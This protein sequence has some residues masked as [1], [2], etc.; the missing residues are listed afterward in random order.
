L[1]GLSETNAFGFRQVLEQEAVG[2]IT[3][4]V[5]CESVIDFFGV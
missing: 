2:Q 3:K 5:D 1:I 4:S